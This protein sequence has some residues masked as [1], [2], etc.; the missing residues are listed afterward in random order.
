MHHGGGVGRRVV[1]ALAR[2][3]AQE[4]IGTVFVLTRVPGFFRRLG[5]V[6]T[7]MES[8]PEKVFKDCEQC[9]K[10]TCC[11]EQPLILTTTVA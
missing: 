7:S 2:R 5:F 6:S 4:S 3:A 9:L 8:L 10:R 1:E 11:D